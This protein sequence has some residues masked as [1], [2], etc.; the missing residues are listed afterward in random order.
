MLEV[1]AG[2][3]DWG[4]ETECAVVLQDEKTGVGVSGR[5]LDQRDA[6]WRDAGVEGDTEHDSDL[7]PKDGWET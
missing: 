2:N 5:E 3:Q 7:G 6:D 1:D 4:A